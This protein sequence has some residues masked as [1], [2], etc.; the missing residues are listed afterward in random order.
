M[1]AGTMI[2]LKRQLY[3]SKILI[4]IMTTLLNQMLFVFSKITYI[5]IYRFLTITLMGVNRIII[6]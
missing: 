5:F 3:L 1:F 2:S 4:M 6:I